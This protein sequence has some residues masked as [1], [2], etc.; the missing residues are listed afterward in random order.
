[1]FSKLEEE[2]PEHVSRPEGAPKALDGIRIVDFTHFIAGPFATM[3]LADMGADVIKV[4]APGR[5]DE[6]RYYPPAHPADETIG[7]PYLWANRNKRSIA[8]DLKS[9]GGRQIARDL[10]AT[11]DIVS[12][13]FSTG[14]MERLGLGYE[15]CRELNPEVIYCSVS[16]YGREG[17]FADR[18][19]FDP[20]AQAESGFVSMNGYPDRQ[21]VRALSP[22][23]DISTAM[24]A[25]N[26]ILGALVA[27][28][29]TGKG[30][31]IEVSLFD[32]AVLMT[33]Y[34][35]L[36]HLF[37]GDEPQRHGNTSPDTCPS[38]VFEA[39]DKAFYI[40]C[41]NNK[42]FHR[43]VAQVLEMPELGADPI[44]ADRNGR[45]AKRA[46]L[47]K[48]LDEAFIQHPW[49]YWQKRMR[50]ASIPCGE[51]RTV[52]EAIRSAEA[53]ERGL[54]SRVHHQEL[55]WLPNVALPFRFGGT[56]VADP[57]P[58]PRVG[59]H[60]GQILRDSLGYSS[61]RIEELVRAGV[62]YEPP[63]RTEPVDQASE[64]VASAS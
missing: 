47:F 40:N 24:M 1:M 12:E 29:R 4:E 21:G 31:A 56:P 41:G 19:G 54:V 63:S 53:R 52:G 27:R 11:A 28:E 61:A 60:S 22:V 15:V 7:A 3:M 26:A 2:F 42:I 58:A 23:M 44:L 45:I 16:A 5:G 37:T 30:Q 8:L 39:S 18:L 13:N 25:C 20:I 10:I 62:V 6:F 43:L 48:V 51:V 33:G 49:S 14:V 34:A 38:G 36:Q 59:E 57:V 17:A 55:G 35:T 9:E 50:D 46:E 64:Q 32:N